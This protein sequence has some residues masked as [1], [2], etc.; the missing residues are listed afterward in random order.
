MQKTSEADARAWVQKN[1]AGWS[2]A[3]QTLATQLVTK[4]GPPADVTSRQIAWYDNG[5][6][7]RTVLYKEGAAHNFPSPHRDVLEQAVSYRV[8]RRKLADVLN[9][10]GS[11]I[12]DRTRGEVAARCG[13]ETE[14]I[15]VLNLVHDIVTDNRNT[16]TAKV[17]H[18]QLIRGMQT[19]DRDSAATELKF[20][21]GQA[22]TGDPDEM[23]PLLKHLQSDSGAE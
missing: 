16:E 4:Y 10:N 19:G 3:T 21:P 2:K 23:A 14:N 5:P 17:Y 8:P 6:W 15:I 22:D 7:R 1:L 11:I 13:S 12:I 9:Y 20:K 18:A